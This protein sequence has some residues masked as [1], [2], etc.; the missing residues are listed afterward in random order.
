MKSAEHRTSNIER[1]TSKEILNAQTVS[2]SCCARLVGIILLLVLA[3]GC[4]TQERGDLRV[5]RTRSV[6]HVAIGLCE[7]YPKDSRSLAAARHDLELLKTN[8]IHVLRISFSWL[9]MEPERG[10]YDFSFWDDF[11]RMAVDE[12]GVQLI[13]YV[14]YTPRWASTSTNA[15]YWQ[16]PPADTAAFAEFIEQL[17]ARY[18]NQ[19]HSWEIWNEPD[20]PY[21]WRGSVEQ[22]EELLR[23]GARAVRNTDPTAKVVMGGLAWSPNFLE[24]V[25]ANTAVITNVDVINLHNYYE[26]WA[27][28]PL[29]RIPDYVGRASDLIHQYEQHQPI[30]LA[31]AGYSDFRRSN[32]VSGQYIARFQFEHTPGA[33]AESLFRVM[34]LALASRKVSLVAWYRIHDLPAAQEVIGDE[35]N[36]HLGILDQ[37]N[38]GKPALRALQFFDSL[39]TNGVKCIDDAVRVSKMIGSPVEVHAFE[40][41]DGEVVVTAWMRTYVPG[42]QAGE[43]SAVPGAVD[44]ELPFAVETSARAFDEVGNALGKISVA[45]RGHSSRIAGL[46]LGQNKVTVLKFQT[47]SE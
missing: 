1:R 11:V 39:F 29:E 31:E 16:Q 34:T 44:L 28:E 2:C 19:I 36:R 15:D 17:V 43:T 26:T 8:N 9:D 23:V 22:F 37:Q 21:Y 38:R 6:E 35:N 5:L 10:N 13:P 3:W 24:G 27:S 25:L 45:R 33:Q 7:D 20:N 42:Q 18:K 4:A 47:T 40:K 14:C 46:L 12:Y 30:W 32:Y 41:S